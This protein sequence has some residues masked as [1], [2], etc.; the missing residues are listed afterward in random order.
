MGYI[1]LPTGERFGIRQQNWLWRL[2]T[3]P[4]DLKLS[5]DGRGML[6]AFYAETARG[7][8]SEND[9]FSAGNDAKGRPKLRSECFLGKWKSAPRFQTNLTRI[10]FILT[11]YVC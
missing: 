2:K 11:A 10:L 1:R 3:I 7:K 9:R 4:R 8:L 5:M 6:R